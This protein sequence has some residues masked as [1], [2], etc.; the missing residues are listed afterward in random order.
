MATL[1][2]TIK[3]EL[4]LN[5]AER[6]SENVISIPSV[7]EMIERIIDTPTATETTLV[8][9]GA[10]TGG[11]TFI[12]ET[13]KYLRV[14]NLDSTNFATLRVLGTSEEYFVNIPAE[15]SF[16]LFNDKMDANAT[17]SQAVSFADIESIKAQA[18]TAA[19]QL[20]VFVAV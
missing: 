12:D 8:E 6:G 9:Y 4:I 10:A 17:G 11:S 5:G 16:M 13:T 19:V 1:T 7:T 2:V 18:N 15:G 20:E 14:T 3:E